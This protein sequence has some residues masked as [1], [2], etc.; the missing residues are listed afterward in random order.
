MAA[1][2]G[3]ATAASADVRKWRSL[4]FAVAAAAALWRA[5]VWWQ[6][7]SAMQASARALLDKA[8]EKR[9][10]ESEWEQQEWNWRSKHSG[11]DSA[12]AEAASAGAKNAAAAAELRGPAAGEGAAS[13]RLRGGAAATAPG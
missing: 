5:S 4:L 9:S 11:G 1:A 12:A 2:R 3:P 6:D 13:A 7:R 10:L 8:E